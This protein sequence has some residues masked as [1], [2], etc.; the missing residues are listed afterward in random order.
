MALSRYEQGPQRLSSVSFSD[1]LHLEN[2]FEDNGVSGQLV[3]HILTLENRVFQRCLSA[4]PAPT[5]LQRFN[6]SQCAH[7]LRDLAATADLSSHSALLSQQLL[8][9]TH[10]W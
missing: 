3:L 8:D 7:L 6:S 5:A 4:Q 10:R 1:N 9:L 2:S